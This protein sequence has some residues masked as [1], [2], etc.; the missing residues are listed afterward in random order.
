MGN[1]GTGTLV[2]RNPFSIILS[3]KVDCESLEIAKSKIFKRRTAHAHARTD[4]SLPLTLPLGFLRFSFCF[5][6]LHNGRKMAENPKAPGPFRKIAGKE[7]RAPSVS[8]A[9][10]NEAGFYY[11]TLI[12]PSVFVSYRPLLLQR[13]LPIVTEEGT[14]RLQI[15]RMQLH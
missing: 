3:R 4:S 15:Q 12:V 8:A 6:R 11:R 2:S 7:S 13:L 5:A 14:L 9:A 1:S 10:Y